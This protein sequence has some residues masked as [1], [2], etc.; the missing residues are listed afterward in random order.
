MTYALGTQLN[1]RKDRF[2]KSDPIEHCI[3]IYSNGYLKYVDDIGKD[4][5]DIKNKFDIEFKYVANGIFT[6]KKK[7][8][9]QK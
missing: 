7:Q 1:E 6:K 9:K 4:H 3:E 5:I 2:D 8:R